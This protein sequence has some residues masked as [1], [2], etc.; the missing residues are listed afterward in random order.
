MNNSAQPRPQ[1]LRTTRTPFKYIIVTS[2]HIN[3]LN[4]QATSNT[5][6]ATHSHNITH[7][8]SLY[9]SLTHAHTHHS[10]TLTRWTHANTHTPPDHHTSYPHTHTPL[11]TQSIHNG[12]WKIGEGKMRLI[13][14]KQQQK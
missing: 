3:Q 4:F 10:H 6:T 7:T 5:Y 1:S 12:N 14:S 9:T 11:H 13:C 8:H 2:I